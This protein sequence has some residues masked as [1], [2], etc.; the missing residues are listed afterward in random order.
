MGN[1]YCKKDY[2][3]GEVYLGEIIQ[4]RLQ[5]MKKNVAMT[6]FYCLVCKIWSHNT[7]IQIQVCN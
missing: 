6:N 5:N 7:F 4:L 1:G 2:S 3:T